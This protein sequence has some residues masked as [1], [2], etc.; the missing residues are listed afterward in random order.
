MGMSKMELI[1]CPVCSCT[2]IKKILNL[3]SGNIDRSTL[4]ENII[5]QSCEKCGHVFN[6]L[7]KDDYINLL[8]YYNH[9]YA[10][11]NIGSSNLGGDR[12]GGKSTYTMNRHLQL[13]NLFKSYTNE[14]MNILDVGCAMGGM[15][16]FLKDQGYDNLYGIDLTQ[17]YLD[18]AAKNKDLKIE[19]GSAEDIPFDDNTFELVILDQVME[20][21]INPKKAFQEAKRVLKK[22]GLFC[23]GVPDA[24][25]YNQEYF[26]DFYWFLMREHIQH[27]NLTNLEILAN[28]EGFELI[29]FSHT[30]TPMMSEKMILPNLNVIFKYT[31]NKKE[32]ESDNLSKRLPF[33][34]QQYISAELN[35]LDKKKILFKKI[36]QEG[37]PVY[38]WGIGR[39]FLYLYE[40]TALKICNIKGLFDSSE[41][42][43]KNSTIDGLAVSNTDKISLAAEDSI[44]IIT[45]IAHQDLVSRVA[46]SSGYKGDIITVALLDNTR[47]KLD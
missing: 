27:F 20:H 36:A 1:N 44:L 18:I 12:P 41:Y 46:I 30:D 45:A 22:G 35:R 23:I 24:G 3:K 40:N 28:L 39:E 4:Y 9:E 17:K 31:G 7:M 38:I 15:L 10:P 32:I 42:K 25:R 21:L 2:N 43:Q 26:F 37:R 47:P 6:R 34:M 13:F 14:E 33:K 16:S 5:I 8:N 19:F 29:K 11:T